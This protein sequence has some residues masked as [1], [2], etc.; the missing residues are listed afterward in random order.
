MLERIQIQE[1]KSLRS[2]DVELAPLVVV[3]G[4]NAAG[5]SNFLEA[6]LLL[7][8][9]GTSRT[10]DEAFSSLRGYP[11]EAFAMPQNGLA[12]LL[13]QERAQLTI[14]A[15][16]EPPQLD[17]HRD[18]LRYRIQLEIQPSVGALAVADEYLARL[19]RAGRP[20][21]YPRI[22]RLEP[23]E[24]EENRPQ[25]AVRQRS[26]PGHPR[27]E[28]I[29]LHYALISDLHYSGERR[30]PEFDRMRA[31][32]DAWRTYYLDPRVA[33]RSAQPPRLVT[34]IGPRGE[35][36]APFL[37]RL[38]NERPREFSAVLR[39]LRSTIPGVE[40][41]DVDLDPQRGTLDIIVQQG[42]RTFSSRVVSEGT[43][44]VLA[45]CAIAANPWRSTLVAF[46]EPENG[47][48]PHRIDTIANLVVNMTRRGRQ[49]VVVTTHS[50]RF[51]ASI[52]SFRRQPAMRESIVLLRA[53]QRDGYTIVDHLPDLPLFEEE[54]I[55]TALSDPQDVRLFER[56]YS[57]GWL[58][59]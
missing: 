37:H 2:V 6:L 1:F 57:R 55:D 13:E 14:E 15:D 26:K 23:A 50:P 10:L 16:L 41:L 36:L 21:D 52:A 28:E 20:K 59:G 56:M 4:P 22:S 54:D 34:D 44:R 31:E 45:L 24:G 12:G 46:E 25:L 35:Q 19:D 17:K 58:D 53:R 40:G 29:G 9:V 49:Q 51:A 30:Y 11:V 32:L 27:H 38:K 3:L 42:G 33:M 47:V 7:S 5:K 43:L 48:H 18:R 8:K 39:G